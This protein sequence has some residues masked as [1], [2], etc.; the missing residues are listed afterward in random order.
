MARRV[1]PVSSG[2]KHIGGTPR[3]RTPPSKRPDPILVRTPT[4][5]G[6]LARPPLLR[7]TSSSYGGAT[8]IEQSA[9]FG[10]PGG[11]PKSARRWARSAHLHEVKSAAGRLPRPLMLTSSSEQTLRSPDWAASRKSLGDRDVFGPSSSS[12]ADFQS[13]N[14]SSLLVDEIT[15]VASP[16]RELIN[17]K[18]KGRG[19]RWKSGQGEVVALDGET[20]GEADEWVDTDVDGTESEGQTHGRR[21]GEMDRDFSKAR[22]GLD[23]M[24]PKDPVI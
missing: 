14:G 2:R 15:L 22:Y 7:A 1:H 18:S 11:L 23:V 17:G 6:N 13:G 4:G 24:Q 19:R 12:A 16:Q 10:T 5:L 21:E 3:A 8:L 9:S 20:A